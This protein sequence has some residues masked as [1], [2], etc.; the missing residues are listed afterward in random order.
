MIRKVS[1]CSDCPFGDD[2]EYGSCQHPS[3][4]YGVHE[5]HI[6]KEYRAETAPDWCPLR[7][8]PLTLEFD[9]A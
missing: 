1:K 9:P 5:N 8:E 4:P 6:R 7:C 3:W 2:N